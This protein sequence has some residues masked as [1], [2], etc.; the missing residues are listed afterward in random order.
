[1]GFRNV[2]GSTEDPNPRKGLQT[3]SNSVGKL[4]FVSKLQYLASLD[5]FGVLLHIIL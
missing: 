1:M 5:A 4:A 3:C 2:Q